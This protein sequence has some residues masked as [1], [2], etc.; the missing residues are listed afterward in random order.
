MRILN[1]GCALSALVA[2][3]MLAG[4]GAPRES[5]PFE[6]AQPFD[7]AQG[8]SIRHGPMPRGTSV[9]AFP[10]GP[11][12]AGW[13]SPAAKI[14]GKNLIYVSAEY[15]SEV[16]I[17]PERGDYRSPIGTIT[18]GVNVPWSLY[19]DKYGSLYV[20][21]QN[22]NTVTAYPAGATKPGLTYSKGLDRPLYPIVDRYGNLFVG[23]ANNG[24]IVEYVGANAN[25]YTVIQ[26]AGNEVDGM[27]FDEQGNLYAAYR[28]SNGASSIEEFAPGSSKGTVLGMALNQPQG[29]VVDNDGNILVVESTS[30]RVDVFPPGQQTPSVEVPIPNTPNQLAIQE[31][32]ANL[33]V[34][35][36]GGAV[37]GSRYPFQKHP[38]VYV[39]DEVDEL[40]QGV[41]LSNGQ[42]F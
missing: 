4:C 1:N 42:H 29:L 27:D 11:R 7:S 35:A 9:P 36:E 39:K 20:A 26:T 10:R 17:Y 30:G 18:D 19:V 40:I 28:A 24:T 12:R 8:D 32:D 23:N 3:A 33:F 15:A 31:T 34:A 21:N 25:T 41:A 14:P 38:R 37:Y 6:S 13:L 2:A 22:N 5:Q 16:L